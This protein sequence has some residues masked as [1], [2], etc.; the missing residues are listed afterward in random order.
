[1]RHGS[2]M[3]I[4]DFTWQTIETVDGRERMSRAYREHGVLLVRAVLAVG[5]VETLRE[6]FTAQVERDPTTCTL[7]GDAVSET[8]VLHRYPRLVQPHRRPDLP[9][10]RAALEMLL[11]RRILAVVEQLIGPAY[12]AQS[13]FYFKPPTARGQAMHQDNTFLQASPETCLA[14]WVAADDV[15][16]QNGGLRVVPGSHATELI[17][18]ESADRTESFTPWG[19]DVPP[20]QPVVSTK[21]RAGDV[22]FFH[23]A[24]IHGSGPNRSIDRFRRSLVLHYVPTGSREVGRFYLP[25]VGADETAISISASN[26]GGPCGPDVQLNGE[27]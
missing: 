10:G 17:C 11:D 18:P 14:A 7:A 22:L 26:G 9:A 13:M 2:R 23:G 16:E 4:L 19:I 1:M 8:D 3:T 24:L 15:D 20:N 5:E 27:P 25:L 12:G 21:M 6:T